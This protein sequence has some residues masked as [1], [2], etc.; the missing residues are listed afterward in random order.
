M[1][2]II[3][4]TFSRALQF[5]LRWRG[6]EPHMRTVRIRVLLFQDGDFWCAQCLDH[7][8]AAQADSRDDLENEFERVLIEHLHISEELGQEPFLG[9]APA[10]DLFHQMYAKAKVLPPRKISVDP[11]IASHEAMSVLPELRQAI[12][13]AH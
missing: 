12:A 5:I 2:T 13:Y 10:P 3:I 11:V 4:E 9:L 6:A 8:L 1:A 7:D